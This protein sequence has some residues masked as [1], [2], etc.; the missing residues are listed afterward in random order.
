MRSGW[1]S[2]SRSA[3]Q[4]FRFAGGDLM[5][6]VMP[7]PGIGHIEGF[8]VQV[9]GL[10]FRQHEDRLDGIQFL[11]RVVPEVHRDETGYVTAIAIDVR[12][13]YPI[14][15]G[16]GHVL[17]QSLVAIVEVDDVGPVQP[18]RRGELTFP[19]ARVPLGMLADE[20]IV[21]CR[22]VGDPVEDYVHVLL[23]SGVDKV[24]EI[25]ERAELWIDAV[26][27]LH[28]IRASQSALAIL[29]ANLVDRHQPE[30]IDSQLFQ[31]GQLLLGGS[32][33]PFGSELPGVDL[34]DSGVL[35]PLGVLELDE[36]D[37]LIRI[38]LTCSRSR[39][40]ARIS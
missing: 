40:A 37:G 35:A 22:V 3:P 25:V 13:L 12:L 15:Q 9:A 36:G 29:L 8:R 32:E 6:G 20:D 21:P 16:I 1:W 5:D 28:G 26:V 19:I 39:R 11:A 2:S 34:I 31:P 33:G 10:P 27:I 4:V 18:R 38:R 14:L 17:A 24:L 23:M 7:G 30:D